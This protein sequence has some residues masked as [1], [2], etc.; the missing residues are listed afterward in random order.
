[1]ED[2][3]VW[4]RQAKALGVE[5]VA[6]NIIFVGN[7]WFVHA[8]GLHAKDEDHVSILESFFEFENASDRHA[9]RADFFEFARNPHRRAAESEA[10]SKFSEEVDVRASDAAM[11]EVAEDGDI[12]IIDFSKAVADSQRVEKALRGMF[13]RAVTCVNHGDVQ[14]ARDKVGGAGRGVTHNQAIRLHGVECLHG[15][16]E[17]F[18]FFHARRFRLQV[19]RV[20]A[21]TGGGGAEADACAGGVFKEGQSHRFAAKGSEFFERITLDCLK[22]PALVEKKSQFV[23]GER[24]ESQK[25]AEAMGHICTLWR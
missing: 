6:E 9:W 25:V 16:E 23:R 21:E 10:A 18:A 19:H 13:V 2:E 22:G 1:M 11:L 3:R 17:G 8:L 14:V 24:F 12:E 15:V 20:R 7:G 4:L 5:L